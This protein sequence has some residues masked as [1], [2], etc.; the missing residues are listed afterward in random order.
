MPEFLT[1]SDRREIESYSK[2]GED[3]LLGEV[4]IDQEKCIGCKLC[5]EACAASS[6]EVVDKKARMVDEMAACIACGD[7][8]AIC[9]ED[10]ISITKYIEF[11]KAFR[12]I[13]RGKPSRPRAF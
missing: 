4:N 7:C 1:F 10:A 13:D 6:L 2:I 9:S 3:V 12:Y 11:K 8:V 5:V